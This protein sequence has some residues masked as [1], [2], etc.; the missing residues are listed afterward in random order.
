MAVWLIVAALFFSS[1]FRNPPGIAD[2]IRTYGAWLDRAGGQ[3]PHVYPW[4]FYFQRLLFFH[5]AGGPFWSEAFI[6]VLAIVGGGAAF[7]RYGLSGANADFARFLAFYT[8][9]LAAAYCV[10]SYK[11]PWCALGFWNGAILL[12]GIGAAA[13]LNMAKYQWARLAMR[14]ALAL[15]ILQL[16]AQAWQASADEKLCASPRNPYVFAQT[17]PN[18]LQL[19]AKVAAITSAQPTEKTTE[20]KVLAP[21]ND[22]WPLPW[23]LRS[24]SRVLLGGSV[25][26]DP[27]APVMIVSAQFNARLDENKTHL[28]AGYFEMRPGVFFELYVEL[29]AWKNY[30]AKNP[31]QPDRE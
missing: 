3:S 15:G 24:Y 12:A 25:P 30:L 9:V 31:P 2:S 5:V 19:V 27:Y 8:V 21:Q 1:F 11:T 23:Y 16:A 10:I 17:S 20:I 22:F 7:A 14:G 18:L 4:W 13:L 6:A 28:M 26:A 29:N